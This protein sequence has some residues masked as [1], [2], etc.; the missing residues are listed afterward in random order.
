MSGESMSSAFWQQVKHIQAFFG[1]TSVAM[2]SSFS[3]AGG[4]S[5]LNEKLSVVC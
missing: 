2:C 3:C 5:Y 1:E 4:F